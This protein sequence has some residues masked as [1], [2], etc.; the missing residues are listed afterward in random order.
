MESKFKK[1]KRA[2]Q[3]YATC[4]RCVPYQFLA[5]ANTG[6]SRTLSAANPNQQPMVQAGPSSAVQTTNTGKTA[7]AG[8]KRT[9]STDSNPVSLRR[10]APTASLNTRN[11]PSGPSSAVS[12]RGRPDVPAQR[13][14]GGRSSPNSSPSPSPSPSLTRS[15]VR[16]DSLKIP[17][18]RLL[19]DPSSGSESEQPSM[20]LRSPLQS[21]R[22]QQ[23]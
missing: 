17:A 5:A 1:L 18:S 9:R 16:G 11:I 13:P 23:R 20:L 10:A 19:P 3:R 6:I 22:R 21:P 4:Y 14:S 8:K 12:S 7:I 15:P 2:G